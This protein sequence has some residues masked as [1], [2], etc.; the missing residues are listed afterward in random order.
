MDVSNGE[1][2][3]AFRKSS[4]SGSTNSACVEVAVAGRRLFVRDSKNPEGGM[5]CLDAAAARRLIT[6]LRG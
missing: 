6:K 4:H 1:F 3:M 2:Q 5:L